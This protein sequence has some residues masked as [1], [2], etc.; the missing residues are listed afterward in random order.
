[1]KLTPLTRK[2]FGSFLEK[3]R[4]QRSDKGKRSLVSESDFTNQ[5]KPHW[6][7]AL[8]KKRLDLIN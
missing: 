2:E 4:A 3:H 8:A 7:V 5:S 6:R 1:M